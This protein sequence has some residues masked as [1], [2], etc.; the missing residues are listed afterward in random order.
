MEIIS[1]TK[2]YIK[3]F[4]TRE[5]SGI[6]LFDL[7]QTSF[8]FIDREITDG[9]N[10]DITFSEI[11]VEEKHEMRI[12]L[13]FMDMYDIDVTLSDVYLGNIDVI[14][15]INNIDNPLNIRK[16]MIIK[17]PPLGQ[18][19]NF[20]IRPDD[21]LFN[22]KNNK[23]VKDLL[24]VPNKST[25]KD[26]SREKFKESGYSLPPVVLRTPKKPVSIS[27]DGASFTISSGGI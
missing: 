4:G 11:L 17:F 12:D 9:I 13:L 15:A 6:T 23:S 18:F 1:L 27:N 14:L 2:D 7:T 25:R 20:R 19:N 8:L 21:D 3:R 22:K 26:K 5:N 24:V 10:L 16:G